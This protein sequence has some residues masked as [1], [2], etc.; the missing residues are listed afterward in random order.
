M[1]CVSQNALYCTTS[2]LMIRMNRVGWIGQ[3]LHSLKHFFLEDDE[4]NIETYS[5]L[6]LIGVKVR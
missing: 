4:K 5:P 3:Q 2:S 6:H 1:M